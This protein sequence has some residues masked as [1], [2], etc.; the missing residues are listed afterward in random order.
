[1]LS[2][3]RAHCDRDQKSRQV[4]SLI[5]EIRSDLVQFDLMLFWE[6]GSGGFLRCEIVPYA[7]V[8]WYD[9]RNVK[10]SKL[11]AAAKFGMRKG[12]NTAFPCRAGTERHAADATAQSGQFGRA[13]RFFRTGCVL[14]NIGGCLRTV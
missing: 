12:T 8:I 13:R 2:R 9:S 11:I 4:F 14:S 7:P 1:M 6:G 3:E 10:T 5:E